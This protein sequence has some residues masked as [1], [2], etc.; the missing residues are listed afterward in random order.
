M[1]GIS[2]ILISIGAIDFGIL[3]DGAVVM[4]EGVFVALVIMLQKLGWRDLIRLPNWV[5]S[6]EQGLIWV[7]HF[8][9]KAYHH[10]SAHPDLLI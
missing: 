1:K 7:R 3:I 9:F 10:Y 8:L 5:L 6:V 2:P 4:V